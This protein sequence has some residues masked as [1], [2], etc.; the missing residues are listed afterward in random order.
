[1]SVCP[2]KIQIS[3]K[4]HPVW[5][6]PLLC[7]NLVTKDP[8]FL[9]LWSDWYNANTNLD[10]LMTHINFAKFFMLIYGLKLAKR[11]LDVCTWRSTTSISWMPIW[12]GIRPS[13]RIYYESEGGIEKSVPRITVWHHKPC[14]VM[15]N[16]DPEGR[17]FLSHPHTNNGFFF[18]LTIKCRILCLNKKCHSNVTN[19]PQRKWSSI[20]H[21]WEKLAVI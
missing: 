11:I 15:A 7:T 19:A 8:N 20:W 16:S 5:S 17:I 2:A 13:I 21:I 1:M 12:L 4:I 14:R 9:K 18:L 10:L 3:L 6:K